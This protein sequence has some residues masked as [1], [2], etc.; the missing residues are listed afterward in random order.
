[1][2]DELKEQVVSTE[3][4]TSVTEFQQFSCCLAVSEAR[5][6]AIPLYRASATGSYAEKKSA[7]C[8]VLRWLVFKCSTVSMPLKMAAPMDAMIS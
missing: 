7:Y 1:M 4:R 5:N 8:F 6:N 3:R 2:I